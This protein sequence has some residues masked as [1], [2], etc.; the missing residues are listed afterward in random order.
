MRFCRMIPGAQRLGILR[1][2]QWQVWI[3]SSLG[4]LILAL[5]LV[6]GCSGGMR[7]STMA[8]APAPTASFAFI[9]NSGSGNISAF[10]VST[11]G[12]LSPVSGSPFPAG[13]G[14]E[15]MALDSIH[16]FLFVS[17]QN[18][19]NLSAFSVNSSTGVVTPVPGSPF[20]TGAMP[21]GVAAR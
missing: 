18:S 10:A 6:I 2:T 21:H 12:V 11:N 4:A 5:L 17:N 14:A 16:K 3:L 9:A 1:V 13:A 7:N 20:A 15:F 8:S 19:N